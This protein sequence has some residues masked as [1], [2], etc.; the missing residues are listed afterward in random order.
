MVITDWKRRIGGSCSSISKKSSCGVTS[1]PGKSPAY[2]HD[3]QLSDDIYAYALSK[4]LTKVASPTTVGLYSSCKNRLNMILGQMEVYMK[5]QTL[6]IEKKYKGTSRPRS[7]QPSITDFLALI[8]RL[9]FYNPIWTKENQDHHNIRFIFV[10]FS[11]WHFAGSDLLWSGLVIRLIQAM[12]MNFGKLQLVLYR[13]AHYDKEDEIKNKKVEDGPNDW[14]PKKICCCPLWLLLLS[15]LVVTVILLVILLKFGFLKPE[16]IFGEEEDEKTHQFMEVFERRRIRVVLNITALD[17][18]SPKKIVAVLDA[19]NLLLSD[20]ESPFISI[21]AVNQEV[22]IEKVNFADGCFSKEDRA[23]ALLNRIVTL[24][25]TVPPLCDNSKLSLFSSLTSNSKLPEDINTREDKDETVVQKKTSYEFVVD[26]EETKESYPLLDNTTVIPNVMEEEVEKLVTSVLA[27][28]EKKLNKYMSDDSMSMRRV[29]NSLRVTVIMIKALKKELPQPEYIAPWVV[30]AN[31]WP[32]RL[33]WIMQCVEDAQ[34][35]ADIDLEREANCYD[36][37]TLWKVF[38]ES[39]AELYVMSAQIKELL[40]HDGDPE[41]L[42][43]FLSLNRMKYPRK[44]ID[45]VKSN[46]LNGTALV[47]GDADDLKKLL[48]MTFGEWSTFRLHFLG[49]PSHL[50]PQPMNMS[51]MSFNSQSQMPS[52]HGGS[53]HQSSNPSSLNSNRFPLK[54]V[55]KNFS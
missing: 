24:A 34:Q 19:V 45:I 3:L 46:D 9:L 22:L 53:N 48:N 1:F 5:Q 17:R 47:F 21:L 30:L 12:E 26:I 6:E 33:S 50:Q 10:Q 15:I 8:G 25:F 31:Q 39:R 37:K 55:V 23:Y 7:L 13:V 4:T 11:A 36:S 54:S 20:E 2:I 41:M 38:S 14:R 28:N 40:E 51:P 32:C 43:R 49:L 29:I 52:F 35:R 44:Y 18:C 42:E 27:S 16:E